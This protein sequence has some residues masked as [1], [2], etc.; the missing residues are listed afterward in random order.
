[1]QAC[2]PAA[3]LLALVQPLSTGRQHA[4]SEV[5]SA[6]AAATDH[7]RKEWHARHA[8]LPAA[9]TRHPRARFTAAGC[10]PACPPPS[11]SPCRPRPPRRLCCV[12]PALCAR[13]ST[14]TPSRC[15]ALGQALRAGG[16]W[17]VVC[18]CAC[19]SGCSSWQ[20]QGG[21]EQRSVQSCAAATELG[22]RHAWSV[23][24][25]SC[26]SGSAAGESSLARGL[27]HQRSWQWPSIAV[28]GRHS[29]V[30]L[31]GAAWLT[32]PHLPGPL[33]L[34]RCKHFEIGGDKK[35]RA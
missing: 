7:W 12:W 26:T 6:A 14:C 21:N 28:H 20:M 5:A 35:V 27:A 10:S 24:S 23:G 18:R 2:F 17:S 25:S 1:M 4:P 8:H 11:L 32:V 34:Q 16:G 9:A 3:R 13:P 33:H 30:A 31:H 29:S 19:W 15:G 22:A